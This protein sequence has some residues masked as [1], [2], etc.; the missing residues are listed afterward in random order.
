[1]CEEEQPTISMI[2]PL[3]AK[4]ETH[5]QH[6]DGDAPLIVDMKRAFRNDFEK[7]YSDVAVANLLYTASAL[8]PR[9]KALPFLKE[10]DTQRIFTNLSVEAA[11]IHAVSNVFLLMLGLQVTIIL[12][13]S[14]SET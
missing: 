2:A 10:Q 8:D 4:L 6:N 14:D 12:I 3:K 5:F 7:R 1:M 13:V 11:L 9:F